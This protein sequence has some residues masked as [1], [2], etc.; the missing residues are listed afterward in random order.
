M[1]EVSTSVHRC[2]WCGEIVVKESTQVMACKEF[3]VICAK[4]L[5]WGRYQGM[6]VIKSIKTIDNI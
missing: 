2:E 4:C 6:V 3:S 5:D 1:G